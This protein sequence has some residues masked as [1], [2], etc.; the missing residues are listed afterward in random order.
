MALAVARGRRRDRFGRLGLEFDDI[1][2]EE[3]VAWSTSS[4]R[5]CARASTAAR[6]RSTKRWPRPPTRCSSATTKA[7]GRNA[8]DR[9]CRC[10]ARCARP[11]RR[12]D[13]LARRRGR[14]ARLLAALCAVRAGIGPDTAWMLLVNDGAR[15]GM[16]LARLAGLSRPA[17]AA[18][19]AAFAEPLLWGEPG[20][21]SAGSTRRAGRCRAARRWWRLPE[22][23]ATA[24]R[25]GRRRWP[26]DQLSR[27]DPAASTATAAC[28]RRPALE[29]LQVDAGC[30]SAGRS[31][32]R[33]WRRWR[34]PPRRWAFLVARA[35]C[36]RQQ[37]RP[38]PVRP[39]R[40]AGRRG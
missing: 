22:P 13:R 2:A 18:M 3:A 19:V 5:Q 14:C 36:R 23:I 7:P 33:R 31:P 11:R 17:A 40:A 39:G 37:P 24:R 1:P 28:R 35:D 16:L 21:R 15:D 34:A 10:V 9:A 26:A 29:R 30:A 12:I 32:C 38:R 8:R 25:N 20:R 27:P 4:R 6:W